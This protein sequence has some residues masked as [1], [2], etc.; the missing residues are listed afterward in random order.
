MDRTL[1][2]QE[3]ANEATKSTVGPGALLTVA[4]AKS[5][6]DE[7]GDHLGQRFFVDESDRRMTLPVTPS[8]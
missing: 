8:R 4:Y 3:M 1:G 6:Y 7:K 5:L 2:H